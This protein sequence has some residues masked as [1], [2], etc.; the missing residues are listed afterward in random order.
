MFLLKLLGMVFLGIL[1]ALLSYYNKNYYVGV[2]NDILGK[3]EDPRPAVRA[4]RGF[5]Y[6]F[7]FPI[8]FVLLLVGLVALIAFLIIA[9]IIAAIIFVLVWITE[10]LLPHELIGNPLLNLFE[11][12]GLRRP[13]TIPDV[14]PANTAAV[15]QPASEAPLTEEP[16]ESKENPAQ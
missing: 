12:L 16:K 5:F 2:F 14:V 15:Q 7:F 3:E 6:G 8:Y 13:E 9:G 10:K 11:K 4:G 1:S